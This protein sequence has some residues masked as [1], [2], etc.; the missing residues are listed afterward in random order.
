MIPYR[1]HFV[2]K[3][4]P[5]RRPRSLVAS[6]P[7]R[8][9]STTFARA[10]A[11]TQQP[12]PNAPNWRGAGRSQ[13]ASWRPEMRGSILACAHQASRFCSYAVSGSSDDVVRAI[14][15]SAPAAAWLGTLV[16]E[17]PPI[18]AAKGIFAAV[19][20]PAAAGEGQCCFAGRAIGN[21]TWRLT[22]ARAPFALAPRA[23]V[24]RGAAWAV[25]AVTLY[26]RGLAASRPRRASPGVLLPLCGVTLSWRCV[27]G[28]RPS[29]LFPSL[30]ARLPKTSPNCG[31]SL[32][33]SIR[34][35]NGGAP[36]AQKKTGGTEPYKCSEDKDV[37]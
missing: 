19:V 25:R 11:Q 22:A 10:A 18:R 23:L 1:A 30:A 3:R 16:P 34:A 7:S 6:P 9:D 14:C 37:K 4:A 26:G 24:Q 5:A 32:E 13:L 28:S 35:P 31:R 20:S 27:A 17:A 36:P 29:T 2:S 33:T 15:A 21:T 8:V 12:S